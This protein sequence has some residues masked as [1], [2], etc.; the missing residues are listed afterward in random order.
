MSEE[1]FCDG[2]WRSLVAPAPRPTSPKEAPDD[3]RDEEKR[4]EDGR[5]RKDSGEIRGEGERGGR[6]GRKALPNSV[7]LKSCKTSS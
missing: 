4:P 6:G 2:I 5:R 1:H 7:W 3:T